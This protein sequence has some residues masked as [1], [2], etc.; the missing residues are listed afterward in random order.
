M[1]TI[2]SNA[3]KAEKSLDSMQDSVDIVGS[4]LD[5]LGGKAKSAMNKITSAFD[6]TASKAKSSGQKVGN[7]F[8]EGMQTGLVQAPV[9]ASQMV[10]MVNAQLSA[11]YSGAYSAGAYISQGFAA[12]ML[13]CLGVIQSAAAQMAAAADEAVKAKAKIHSPSKVSEDSGEDYGQGWING[14][15]SKVKEAW[16]AS[17][18]LVQIPDVSTPNLAFAYSGEMSS[19]YDYYRNREYSF[20]IPVVVDGRE[21]AKA[22]ASYTQE[23]L[24]RRQSR[25]SRKHGML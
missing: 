6:D 23:E 14:I 15:M 16:A 18:R 11:G 19:E 5:A 17:E 10:G 12:G 21:V 7:G 24:D 1:K 22:T 13:S 4:G 20:E 2:A 25:E 8:T 9:I 3:K